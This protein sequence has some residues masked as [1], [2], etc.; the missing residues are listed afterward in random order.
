MD[1]GLKDNFLKLWKRYFKGAELPLVFYYADEEKQAEAAKPPKGHRC[2]VG[3]LQRVRHGTSLKF[4]AETIGCGGGQRYLGFSE[5]LRPEFEYFLSYGIP[6]KF[7]GERYKKS[8]ELVTDLLKTLPSFKAPSR[9]IVFKR[10]DKLQTADEPLVA[11]FLASPDVLSGLFTLA[12]YDRNDVN[13]VIAPFGAGCATIVQYPYLEIK[14]PRPRAVIG[15]LDVSARP[16]VHANAVSFA[17]PLQRLEQM[18]TNMEESFLITS[19]W[20][21]VSRRIV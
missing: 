8:P 15:M 12:N 19:S 18:V 4:E 11:F 21:K 6:G 16:C 2:I 13:G 14:M 1:M 10:W 17:L 7:E 9:Y 5:S 3:D 20:R